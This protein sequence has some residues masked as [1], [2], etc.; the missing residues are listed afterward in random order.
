MWFWHPLGIV[1]TTQVLSPI[2]N[3]LATAGLVMLIVGT[4]AFSPV[5]M[6]GLL[7]V[8]FGS[9]HVHC[10]SLQTLAKYLFMM[11]PKK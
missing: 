9:N 10:F 8:C 5:D 1:W 7:T 4:L 11:P 3:V 2:F 6:F